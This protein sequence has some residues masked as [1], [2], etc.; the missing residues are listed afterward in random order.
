MGW[1]EK[2]NSGDNH[3][4]Y[5][6]QESLRR[7]GVDLIGNKRVQYAVLGCKLKSE[8]MISICFQGKQFII[9]VIRVC[10]PTINAKEA[11]VERFYEHLQGL[12]ELT[13]KK[14]CP[15]HYRGLGCK[16][17][18]SRD[19]QINRQVWP[20]LQNEAGQRLTVLLRVHWSQQTPFSNYARDSSTHEHYQIVNTKIT[21]I[22]FFAAET[23]EALYSQKNKN[24][25]L[26]LAQIMNSLLQNS[27]FN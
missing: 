20:E 1:R 17:R 9:T 12:L 24:W 6:G 27:D 10:A 16:S 22:I 5:N 23:R 19:T 18:Q 7:N 25:E 3:I 21:L 11:E 15:F 14:R 13:P 26:T 4:Y 2:F 8:R